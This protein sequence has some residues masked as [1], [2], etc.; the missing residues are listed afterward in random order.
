MKSFVKFIIGGAVVFTVAKA[1]D[2]AT[3]IATGSGFYNSWEIL[4]SNGYHEA[5]EY[6]NSRI[7]NEF[8]RAWMDK[9]IEAYKESINQENKTVN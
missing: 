4:E 2:I 8:S 6:L 1:F 3:L 9:S 5:A 7:E